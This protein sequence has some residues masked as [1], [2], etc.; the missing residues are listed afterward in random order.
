MRS[1]APTDLSRRKAQHSE[2]L[3]VWAF[4]NRVWNFLVK[5]VRTSELRANFDVLM[6]PTS[7]ALSAVSWASHPLHS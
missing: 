7:H 3:A 6:L 5:P 1:R 4:R 2:S